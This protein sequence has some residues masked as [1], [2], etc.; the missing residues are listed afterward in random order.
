M[1]QSDECGSCEVQEKVLVLTGEGSGGKGGCGGKVVSAGA[2]ARTRTCLEICYSRAL[3]AISATTTLTRAPRD[4]SL[5]FSSQPAFLH[6]EKHAATLPTS[7]SLRLHVASDVRYLDFGS[8]F[9][10]ISGVQKQTPN[11][12]KSKISAAEDRQS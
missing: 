5:R 11:A 1:Q 4:P 9:P 6:A 2:A 10:A 8:I 3:A 7:T 12:K